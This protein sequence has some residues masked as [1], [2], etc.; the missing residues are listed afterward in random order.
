VTLPTLPARLR[1]LAQTL[2]VG[3]RARLAT[4]RGERG[5]MTTEAVILTAL[6]VGLAIAAVAILTRIVMSWVNSIAGPGA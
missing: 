3:L 1:R 5:V 6:I 2:D 4:P